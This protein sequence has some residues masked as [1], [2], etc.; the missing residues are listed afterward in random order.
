M[1]WAQIM[2]FVALSFY[3]GRNKEQLQILLLVSVGTWLVL[4]GLFF[5][6]ID[7]S[8]MH[9]FFGT[10]TAPQ[11]TVELF[12]TSTLDNAKF[13]AC[14]TNTR[15]YIAECEEEVRAWMEANYEIL[16]G[17]EWFIVAKVP[18]DFLPRR[19]LDEL[20]E[21]AVGG[22]REK[23]QPT[24][25]SELKE[26]VITLTT[27]DTV[28]DIYVIYL[29]KENGLHSN[30]NTMIAMISL[31]TLIQLLIVLAQNKKKGWKTVLKEGL[32]T[33][34]FMRPF[35]DAWRVRNKHDDSETTADPLTE[36]IVNKATEL[37]T[38]SIPGCVL[39]LYVL[40][41]NPSLGSG[42]GA[43]ISIIISAFMTGLTSTMIAFDLDT[44]ATQRLEQPNFCGYIKNGSEQRG[45]TFLLMTMI[46]SLHNLS[47]SLGYAILAVVDLNLA[48]KFFV[49][50]V[51]AFLLYKMLRRDFY[52]WARL[53]GVLSVVMAL[54]S[55]T[56]VKVVV[57]FT[58]SGKVCEA[59]DEMKC[60]IWGLSL[61]Y[62]SFD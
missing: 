31:N 53:E 49:G 12:R 15:S 13:R 40:L 34:L 22:V 27:V 60:I 14:F 50:E 23:L 56:L 58:V 28:T 7:R 46:S 59:R 44:N 24:T 21:A 37:A 33:V 38:E 61:I 54:F 55:R 52:L 16:V 5:A 51:G 20:N 11:Y 25:I 2:P 18:D 29:Y 1:I 39:Q 57:D 26:V 36:M 62:T 17:E 3:E 8:Y 10:K 42:S 48:L 35:V 45:R 19:I 41:L 6:A 43:I 4:N 47:R 32:I 30:A 9:T